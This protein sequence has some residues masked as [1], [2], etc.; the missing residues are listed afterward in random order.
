VK[1]NIINNADCEVYS[2]QQPD[3]TIS[4]HVFKRQ[5]WF[6]RWMWNFVWQKWLDKDETVIKVTGW[7]SALIEGKYGRRRGLACCFWWFT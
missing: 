4:V 7:R 2:I 3:G 6:F 5:H 1:I